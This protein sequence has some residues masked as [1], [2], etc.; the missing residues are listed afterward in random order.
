MYVNTLL[1][2]KD[3]LSES[4]GGIEDGQVIDLVWSLIT[5]DDKDSKGP[6]LPR[7]IERLSAFKRD[8]ALTQRELV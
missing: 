7:L 6:I 3:K 5:F 2:L 8:T 4:A 1:M